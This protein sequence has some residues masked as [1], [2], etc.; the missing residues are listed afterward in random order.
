MGRSLVAQEGWGGGSGGQGCPS[1]KLLG[2]Q[3]GLRY[4]QQFFNCPFVLT[5]EDTQYRLQKEGPPLPF[6]IPEAG[7]LTSPTYVSTLYVNN[8]LDLGFFLSFSGGIV[9]CVLFLTTLFGDASSPVPPLISSPASRSQRSPSPWPFGLLRCSVTIEPTFVPRF[10]Y[11]A[12]SQ[13]VS[14]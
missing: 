8:S 2:Q 6:P 5:S 10:E 4:W 1:L 7:V 13:G 9:L 12:G 11:R 3:Q 14:V